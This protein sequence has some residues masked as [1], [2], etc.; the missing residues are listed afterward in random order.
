YLAVEN[1]EPSK[2]RA[3]SPQSNGICERFH[4]TVLQEFYQVAFRKKIYGS[5]W[6]RQYNEERPYSGKYC[7][8]K[9]PM[10]KFRDTVCLAKEKMIGYNPITEI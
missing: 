9:I 7:Y 4:R 3:K 5:I 10:E 1:I 6:V 2:T 8:G